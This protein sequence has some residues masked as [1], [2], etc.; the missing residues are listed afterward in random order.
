MSAGKVK[1]GRRRTRLAWLAKIRWCMD[2]HRWSSNS[3]LRP[4]SRLASS[5][6]SLDILIT[7][8]RR[9]LFVLEAMLNA[10]GNLAATALTPRSLSCCTSRATCVD[11]PLRSRPSKTMKAPRRWRA[12]AVRVDEADCAADASV[13]RAVVMLVS[14]MK[15]ESE[16]GEETE[17]DEVRR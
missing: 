12:P 8:A 15:Q 1:W 2:R 7:V 3:L 13:V 16:T 9:V 14:G 10:P 17:L 4:H 6:R 11:L 5:S